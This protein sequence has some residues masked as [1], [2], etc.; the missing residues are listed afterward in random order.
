MRKTRTN[1]PFS[2]AAAT[3]YGQGPLGRWRGGDR[4]L[5]CRQLNF[6]RLI[7]RQLTHRKGRVYLHQTPGLGCNFDEKAVAR[8]GQW[9][10]A[11]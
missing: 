11:R 8:Y 4:V 7:D 10:I 3:W 5:L 6:R 9:T 2:N 1:G